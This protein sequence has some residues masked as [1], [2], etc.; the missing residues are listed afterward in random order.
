MSRLRSHHNRR[1]AKEIK[2]SGM[3]RPSGPAPKKFTIGW[4]VRLSIQIQS[5]LDICSCGCNREDHPGGGPCQGPYACRP[6][7]CS[8]FRLAMG[9]GEFCDLFDEAVA[10]ME[11]DPPNPDHFFPY[12]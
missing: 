7:G 6:D 11:A 3:F 5:P 1:R 12:P 8:G 4:G 2:R 10:Y 9:A